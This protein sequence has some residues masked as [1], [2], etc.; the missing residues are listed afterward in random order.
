MQN[1]RYNYSLSFGSLLNAHK[2]HSPSLFARDTQLR[3]L[4]ECVTIGQ[5][6]PDWLSVGTVAVSRGELVLS[7]K[8]VPLVC[9]VHDTHRANA[10]VVFRNRLGKWLG[11]I[12][13]DLIGGMNDF[14]KMVVSPGF[15]EASSRSASSRL[16]TLE[17]LLY[18]YTFRLRIC[19]YNP[20]Q[21]LLL[22]YLYSWHHTVSTAAVF[23]HIGYI[24]MGWGNVH[25]VGSLYL[26]VFDS[27]PT[28]GR[29]IPSLWNKAER[30][31]RWWMG[32]GFLKYNWQSVIRSWPAF[33]GRSG[34]SWFGPPVAKFCVA[35]H[36]ASHDVH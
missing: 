27:V 2:R 26:F 19:K 25:H 22:L 10:L 29:L 1:I 28:S 34:R 30:M 36:P 12:G 24:F 35:K 20:L 13:K 32:G 31:N 23:L 9:Y 8:K 7:P 14:E 5:R 15:G 3:Q 4:C 21:T 16:E 11:G 6:A 33:P 18:L 17:H